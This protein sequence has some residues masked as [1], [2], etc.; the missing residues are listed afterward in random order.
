MQTFIVIFVISWIAPILFTLTNIYRKIG[1]GSTI[2]SLFSRLQWPVCVPIFNT[3]ILVIFIIMSVGKWIL[4]I[5][6]K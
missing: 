6:I 3:I 1:K 4:N 5:R 2:K